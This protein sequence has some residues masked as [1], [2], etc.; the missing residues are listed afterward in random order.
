MR[1][2]VDFLGGE[3]EGEEFFLGDGQDDGGV[4]VAFGEFREDGD[5]VFVHDFFGFGPGIVDGD[6]N[7]E[8]G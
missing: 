2:P 4:A 3:V 7:T 5:S 6:F 8:I 1:V